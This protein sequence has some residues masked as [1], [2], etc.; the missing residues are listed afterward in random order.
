MGGEERTRHG[1]IDVS[2]VTGSGNGQVQFSVAANSGPARDRVGTDH[3]RAHGCGAPGE[4][5]HLHGDS[6][7]SGCGGLGRWRCGNGHDRGRVPVD[8]GERADWIAVTTGSGTGPGQVA[9]T[10]TPNLSPPRTGRLTI[11]PASR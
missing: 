8:G 11:A 2:G 4:R 7:D 5:L 9:F 1:W 6:A 3:R 10:T